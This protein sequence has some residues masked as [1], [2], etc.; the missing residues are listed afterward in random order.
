M[1]TGSSRSPAI[2]GPTEWSALRDCFSAQPLCCYCFSLRAFLLFPIFP[3]FPNSGSPCSSNTKWRCKRKDA[4]ASQEYAGALQVSQTEAGCAHTHTDDTNGQVWERGKASFLDSPKS[5]L[6]LDGGPCSVAQAGL[7]QGEA[8]RSLVSPERGLPWVRPHWV[9][10]GLL[11]ALPSQAGD[12]PRPAA[13]AEFLSKCAVYSRPGRANFPALRSQHERQ[14][15]SIQRAP[16]TWFPTK[17]N[18][19]RALATPTIA[20]VSDQRHPS[21][22]RT[23]HLLT[24]RILP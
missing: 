9:S 2:T 13:P 16:A 3:L 22:G 14:P 10:N 17:C 7:A 21:P 11:T 12:T 18:A 6:T 19:Y 1:E 8:V 20:A 24:H 4:G 15:P 23:H 5:L